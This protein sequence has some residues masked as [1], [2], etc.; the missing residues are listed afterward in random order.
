[1][2]VRSLAKFPLSGLGEKT[3]ELV[4]KY[5]AWASAR[6]TFETARKAGSLE[7]DVNEILEL[8]QRQGRSS[9]APETP[10]PSFC[11]RQMHLLHILVFRGD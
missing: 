6:P 3:L 10:Q 11:G 1:M 4:L 2:H 7:K 8:E 5:H 9:N